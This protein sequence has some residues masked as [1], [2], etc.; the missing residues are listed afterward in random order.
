[1]KRIRL[2]GVLLALIVTATVSRGLQN[3]PGKGATSTSAES[4][5][6]GDWRGES[7]CVVRES[8]CRDEDSLYQFSQIP[9]KP[10]RYSLKADKIVDGKPITMGT[11]ECSYDRSR[12]VLECA[13]SASNTLRFTVSGNTMQGT[14]TTRDNKLWRKITLKKVGG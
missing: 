8:A 1:M 6:A 4:A 14:M 2:P 12:R 7:V 10:D 5:P 13:I 3:D 11:T 9:D